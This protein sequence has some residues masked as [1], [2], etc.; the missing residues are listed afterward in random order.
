MKKLF[1][2]LFLGLVALIG[3][4]QTEPE[5]V[6]INASD[7]TP[8]QLEKIRVDEQLKKVEDYGKWVG[9]GKEIGTAVR[10]G[11]SG[12]VDVADKFGNTNV[13]K[14]TIGLII[15]KVA[16]VDFIRIL[17]GIIFALFVTRLV[18]ISLRKTYGKRV[19][20][21]GNVFFFWR[22]REYKYIEPEDYEGINI[23]RFIHIL[24][25]AGAYGVTYAIMF[26]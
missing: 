17:L 16:G 10:E 23:F 7:L 24:A 15:W 2:I 25:L 22:D 26:G 9:V 19:M 14:I 3:V 6:I 21:K 1:L 4:S 13:G 5:K 8:A 20:I 11:L 12:V 18:F